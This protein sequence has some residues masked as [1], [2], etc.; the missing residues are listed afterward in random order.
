ME[1]P[2]A[3]SARRRRGLASDER[4][5]RY[6]R[7]RYRQAYRAYLRAQWRL[8][9]IGVVILLGITAALAALVHGSL[10]RGLLIGFGATGTAAG[11]AHLVVLGSGAAPLMMGELAEQWTASEL[12]PLQRIGWRV[13]NHFGLT[14]GDIDHVAVGS[15]GVFVVETKWSASSWSEA[16]AR[17][18]VESA[19]AQSERNAKRMT[20]WAPYKQLELPAPRPLVVLWGSGSRDLAESLS[21]PDV[22]AGVD[23]AERLRAHGLSNSRLT[24]DQIDGVWHIMNE[25]LRKRDAAEAATAPIPDSLQSLTIR[26][27][28]G[29][30]AGL[31]SIV[32]AGYLLKTGIPIWGWFAALLGA[33]GLE[34]PLRRWP[35][36]QNLVTGSQTGL[37][38]TTLLAG[39]VAGAQIIR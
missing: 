12:R 6:A 21:R 11:V 22:V 24:A 13:V 38:V 17:E 7:R 26:F 2:K 5:G 15:L 31:V 27:A 14:A 28:S 39:A 35:A 34:Q 33:V 19:F 25:H 36:M 3:I 32:A 16:W 1:E 18:D 10:V 30:G 4:A 9:L 37:L 29:V 23:L 8:L 20:M